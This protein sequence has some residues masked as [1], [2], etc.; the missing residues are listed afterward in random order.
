M[1]AV[2]TRVIWR[3]LDAS[4]IDTDPD[5]SVITVVMQANGKEYVVVCSGPKGMKS[6]E[7]V[8]AIISA[9]Q[10]LNAASGGNVSISN[11]DADKFDTGTQRAS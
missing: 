1:S 7:F 8:P 11:P 5:V 2:T 6:D 10:S 3:T 9:G 4:W